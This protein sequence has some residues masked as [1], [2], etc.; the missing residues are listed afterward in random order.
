MF[1]MDKTD[2]VQM[3]DPKIHVIVMAS[4]MVSDLQAVIHVAPDLDLLLAYGMLVILQLHV[5]VMSQVTIMRETPQ[6]EIAT[7]VE[8]EQCEAAA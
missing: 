3:E 1:R 7:I 2:G 6:V 4:E 8:E 5:V